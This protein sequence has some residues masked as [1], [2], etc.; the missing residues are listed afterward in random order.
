[1]NRVRKNPLTSYGITVNVKLM[2]QSKT[3]AC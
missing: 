2:E 1:M 3:Q